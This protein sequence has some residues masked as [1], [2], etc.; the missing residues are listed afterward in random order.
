MKRSIVV[1]A[2]L[3]TLLVRPVQ[4]DPE[5]RM[6][7]PNGVPRVEI[8]GDYRH[9]RYA[10][11]RADT[12]DGAFAAITTGDVLCLGPCFAD[13]FQALP[14]RT[15]WYRF[16][17]ILADGTL[18]RFGPYRVTI[19]PRLAQRLSA[20]MS[21]NPGYGAATVTLF[22]A[23]VPGTS[24]EA[25]AALFDLQGRQVSQI[26]QGPLAAGITRLRWSGRAERGPELRSGLYLLRVT[27]AD[28]RRA[29]ARVIRGR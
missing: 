21:P 26:F 8:A 4:A 1:T 11:W 5:L 7:Y 25:E 13:D 9:S 20:S 16:D 15:Y 27:T 3:A 23:G 24:V 17:L 29:V 28:G 12:P 18:A 22:L 6:A 10:V 14:G 19:D 2:L